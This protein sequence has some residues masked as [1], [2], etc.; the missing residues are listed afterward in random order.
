MIQSRQHTIRLVSMDYT[1]VPSSDGK[2]HYFELAPHLWFPET[3]EVEGIAPGVEIPAAMS[4]NGCALRA[5]ATYLLGPML[6]H[7]SL[8]SICL[9]A[10][11]SRPKHEAGII[12]TLTYRAVRLAEI[13]AGI[14]AV[15][16]SSEKLPQGD[17]PVHPLPFRQQWGELDDELVAAAQAYARGVLSGRRGQKAVSESLGVSIATAGRRVKAAKEALYLFPSVGTISDDDV[18]AP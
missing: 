17:Y 5:H 3:V 10:V 2:L 9:Q 7:Y 16:V 13:L 18:P 4:K 12:N 14:G 11:A 15:A 1:A 8:V 6:S